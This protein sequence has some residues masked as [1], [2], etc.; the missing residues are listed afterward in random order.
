[1]GKWCKLG[2]IREYCAPVSHCLLER[3]VPCWAFGDFVIAL[4]P[5]LQ[6]HMCHP[7]AQQRE[8]K[9]SLSVSMHSTIPL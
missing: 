7:D 6:C 2:D 8:A 4:I 5:L 3:H 1:M 9:Q